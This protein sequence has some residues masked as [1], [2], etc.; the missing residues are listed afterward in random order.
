M[1]AELG[2]PLLQAL[3]FFAGGGTTFWAILKAL[4]GFLEA[5]QRAN[6][7]K[8]QADLTKAQAQSL[9]IEAEAKRILAV[10]TAADIEAKSK[11]EVIA[12]ALRAQDAGTAERRAI[13]TALEAMTAQAN[14]HAA[15]AN[16]LAQNTNQLAVLQNQQLTE[17]Q[18]KLRILAQGGA[19][20]AETVAAHKANIATDAA[21]AAGAQVPA[22]IA[23]VVHDSPNLSAPEVAPA[24]LDPLAAP[25]LAVTPGAAVT[26][27]IVMSGV[28]TLTPD[29]PL[30]AATT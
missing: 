24:T 17:A 11:A 6:L 29:A 7:L 2:S 21:V 5:R 19:A 13:V 18:N 26:G 14:A 12:S 20:T 15:T 1:T 23:S 4:A 3:L 16:T 22:A 8:A 27:N 30:D 10:A 9:L 25:H 28:A